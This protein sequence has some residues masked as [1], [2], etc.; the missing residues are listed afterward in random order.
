[1]SR[2]KCNWIEWAGGECPV[3]ADTHVQI[4]AMVDDS[5]YDRR[6]VSD[7]AGWFDK[8]GWWV[9]TDHVRIIAY[10]VRKVSP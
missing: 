9:G 3:S 1:M 2:Q 8:L 7:L 4:K 5:L 6:G 10:R